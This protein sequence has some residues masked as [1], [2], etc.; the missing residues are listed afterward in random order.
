MP[1]QRTSWSGTSDEH[2][3]KYWCTRDDQYRAGRLLVATAARPNHLYKRPWFLPPLAR[4]LSFDLDKS[5]G[6]SG[7]YFLIL[8][9]S[10]AKTDTT[11]SIKLKRPP[12]DA[13]SF[14]ENSS[15]APMP[16][17]PYQS[18]PQDYNHWAPDS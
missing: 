6:W 8:R 1:H 18:V 12:L 16:L 4:H 10:D 2:N 9:P 13:G 17:R 11:L 14:E 5:R 3:L 15:A 7:R